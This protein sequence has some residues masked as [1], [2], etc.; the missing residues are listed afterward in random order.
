V[1]PWAGAK[2]RPFSPPFETNQLKLN[3]RCIVYKNHHGGGRLAQPCQSF[4]RSIGHGFDPRRHTKLLH[5]HKPITGCHVAAHDWATWHLTNQ[6]IYATCQLLIGPC[7]PL[8][9]T[10]ILSSHPATSSADV[11]RAT[12]HP[13]SGDTCHLWIGSSV[14]QTD[15]S[16]FATCHH[17]RL[18]RVIC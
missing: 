15:L 1:E 3:S 11:T 13:Y 4:A 12:C 14:R 5:N 17:P 10:V 7:L 9:Q 16:H 2:P 6:P 18:P 8:C